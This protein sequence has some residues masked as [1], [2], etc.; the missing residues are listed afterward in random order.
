MLSFLSSI[1][2]QETGTGAESG[3]REVGKARFTP[4]QK[5]IFVTTMG[6]TLTFGSLQTF[7]VLSSLEKGVGEGELFFTVFAVALI[8]FRLSVGKRADR[9]PR[10]TLIIA[11]GL[12]TL[13]GLSMLAYT[14]SLALLLAGS[15][16]YAF[17]FTYLP[18][19]LSALLLDHTPPEMRGAALGIFMAV[20]DVGIGLGGIAMGPVADLL[21]Y[22]AMYMVGGTVAAVSLIYF[23]NFIRRS[24]K[25]GSS[26]EMS[27]MQDPPSHWS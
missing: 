16:V 17:G 11:S 4:L 1:L 15:L 26:M 8:L 3:A 6:F 7:I 24:E 27:S 25:P 5:A 12:V 22:S 9:I 20:F 21:G 10:R 2:V 13:A 23:F 18:T 19:T 14:N